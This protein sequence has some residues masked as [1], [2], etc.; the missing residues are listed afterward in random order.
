MVSM[1]VEMGGNMR[2]GDHKG[3]HNATPIMCTQLFA[4]P[5]FPDSSSCADGSREVTKYWPFQSDL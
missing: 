1:E 2:A 5:R 4:C 3:H